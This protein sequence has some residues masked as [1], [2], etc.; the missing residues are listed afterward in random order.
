METCYHFGCSSWGTVMLIT[1]VYRD[2]IRTFLKMSSFNSSYSSPTHQKRHISGSPD[3]AGEPWRDRRSGDT[4]PD[5]AE[6]T[7]P[8]AGCESGGGGCHLP[9]PWTCFWLWLVSSLASCCFASCGNYR[10]SKIIWM[11]CFIRC[12]LYFISFAF[13]FLLFL[14]L[15]QVWWIYP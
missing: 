10:L 11:V 14:L 5:A 4:H 6:K 9:E 12:F 2:V 13:Y 15:W 7:S 1:E 3:C 8:S